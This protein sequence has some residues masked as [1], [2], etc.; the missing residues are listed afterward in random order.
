MNIIVPVDVCIKR[1]YR[2]YAN[3]DENAT[4]KE[5]LKTITDAIIENQDKEL[6][7]DPDL[8]IDEID[9][10][11]MHIDHDGAWTQEED[12]DIKEILK[13]K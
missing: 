9:I 11:W 10:E 1:Y 13:G 7:P 2:A 3:V 12:N 5:I 4:E 8:D 6:M